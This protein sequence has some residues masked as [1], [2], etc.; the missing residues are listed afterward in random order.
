LFSQATARKRTAIRIIANDMIRTAF[1]V[2]SPAFLFFLLIRYIAEKI[3]SKIATAVIFSLT[4]SAN[5]F[6]T[7]FY[8]LEVTDLLTSSRQTAI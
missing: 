4:P 3:M 2:M 5:Q 8:R 6:H 7:A 1:N